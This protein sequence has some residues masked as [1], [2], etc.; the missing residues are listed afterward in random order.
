MMSEV[1]LI[2]GIEKREITITD[3]DPAWPAK[4]ELH[5]RAIAGALCDVALAIEH[6]GSTAAPGLAA[7]PIIDI[8]VAVR[9]S[10]AESSYRPRLEAA[11]YVLRVRES[12]WNEHRMFRTLKKTCMCISTPSGVWK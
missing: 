5:R 1:G 9:E 3:Y 11:G 6:V 12:D 2:G 8:L 10:A 4:F 7:K